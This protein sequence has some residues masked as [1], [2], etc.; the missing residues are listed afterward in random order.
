ML[1]LNIA[2]IL[3][4]GFVFFHLGGTNAEIQHW[5]DIFT[6]VVPA[7]GMFGIYRIW[8]SGVEFCPHRFYY[9]DDLEIPKNKQWM[10]GP[11]P[12]IS[13]LK[14]DGARWWSN[15][16]FGLL[17]LMIAWIFAMRLW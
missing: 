16:L 9:Q 7:F 14:L 4:F 5:R 6:A 2:P 10:I 17:H 12:T 3:F 11:E 1:I 15:L 13:S 8:I